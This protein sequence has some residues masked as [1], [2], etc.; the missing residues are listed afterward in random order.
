MS[1]SIAHA[2][3]HILSMDKTTWPVTK[4]RL[5]NSSIL[6]HKYAILIQVTF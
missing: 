3:S 4:L 6:P 5:D 1:R 2:A